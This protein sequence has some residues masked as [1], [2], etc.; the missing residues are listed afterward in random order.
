M[1]IVTL[2]AAKVFLGI[3]DTSK[4]AL[5]TALIPAVEAD[6]LRIRNKK[7]DTFVVDKEDLGIGDGVETE[8]TVARF[9]TIL[10]SEVVYVQRG[11]SSNYT[12]VNATG[13]I[14]FDEAPEADVRVEADYESQVEYYPDGSDFTASQMIG[15]QINMQK[16]QGIQAESLGD[17][18]ITY[19]TTSVGFLEGYPKS[20]VG[21]ITRFATFV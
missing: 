9:P 2:E 1:A 11:R 20:I 14:T 8:F 5:I 13:V 21:S 7:W 16:S 18:S 17:H 19:P 4:D 15:Y 12:I 3:T 6:Y 10:D